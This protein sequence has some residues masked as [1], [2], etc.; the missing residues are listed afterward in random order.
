MS[1][2]VWTHERTSCAACRGDISAARQRKHAVYCSDACMRAGNRRAYREANPKRP[3]TTATTGAIHELLV[4]A[5]L[6]QRGFAVFRALSASCPCDLAVLQGDRLLRVEVTSGVYQKG[7][8][9]NYPPHPPDRFDV[10]AVVTR[11]QRI[12]YFPESALCAP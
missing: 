2:N 11:D 8:G 5:D 12:H 1:E 3:F 10:L 6:L 9:V 7:G 4:S